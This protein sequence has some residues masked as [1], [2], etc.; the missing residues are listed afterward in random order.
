MIKTNIVK[1]SFSKKFPEGAGKKKTEVQEALLTVITA[2]NLT[3][4]EQVLLEEAD[5]EAQEEKKG[6]D[7]S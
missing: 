1:V 3:P 2:C 7:I 4:L 5:D 6:K